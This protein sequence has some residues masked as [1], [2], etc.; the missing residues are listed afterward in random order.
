MAKPVFTQNE[1]DKFES[2]ITQLVASGKH[3]V[4]LPTGFASEEI[5]RFAAYLGF[6]YPSGAFSPNPNFRNFRIAKKGIKYTAK[7]NW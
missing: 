2:K 1:V 4:T 3:Q 6:Y 7:E 5:Q